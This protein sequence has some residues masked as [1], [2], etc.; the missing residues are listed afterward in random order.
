MQAERPAGSMTVI[1]THKRKGAQAAAAK[2]GT[3]ALDRA[4][5]NCLCCGKVYICMGT[6]NDTSLFVG[7]PA[8]Y[9]GA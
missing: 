6:T 7:A 3:P 5:A 8:I 4:V 1:H 2:A 9:D